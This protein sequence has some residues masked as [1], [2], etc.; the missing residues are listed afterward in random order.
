MIINGLSPFFLR[1]NG[2]TYHSDLY[3]GLGYSV[4]I[5]MEVGLKS[6]LPVIP[7]CT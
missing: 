6:V 4:A 3:N 1:G 7:F 5:S 2:D